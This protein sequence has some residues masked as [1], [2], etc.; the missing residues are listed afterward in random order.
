MSALKTDS[1][2]AAA[3]FRIAP[4]PDGTEPS[5][6]GRLRVP[7][8][9]RAPRDRV[10]LGAA[11]TALAVGTFLT[12]HGAL[13]GGRAVEIVYGVVLLLVVLGTAALRT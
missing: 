4:S 13:A 2:R 10:F 6:D 8:L 12:I 7:L 1:R 11:I 9:V 3:P 5:A